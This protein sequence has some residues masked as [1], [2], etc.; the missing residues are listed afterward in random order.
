VVEVTRYTAACRRSGNWW[1]ISIPELKG[2][3]SQAK[4]L[5]QVEQ[6]ARDAIAVFLDVARDSFDIDVQPEVPDE[7]AT[8][9]A[10]RIAAVAAER[11]ATQATIDAV[12][13]LLGRGLTVRDA[14]RLLHL[15]PQRI[16]QLAPKRDAETNAA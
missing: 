12:A 9:L 3:H 5:D 11:R 10:A 6:M 1:A 16:S 2:V 15:S 14:G 13:T 4:R 7:V 8:A